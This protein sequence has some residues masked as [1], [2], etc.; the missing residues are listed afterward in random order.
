MALCIELCTFLTHLQSI[1]KA[2]PHT[3]MHCISD[4][5]CYATPH[6]PLHPCLHMC[7]LCLFVYLFTFVTGARCR[8]D[9]SLVSNA[10]I[11]T[12]FGPQ[13]IT[14]QKS[15]HWHAFFDQNCRNQ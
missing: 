11:G 10:P 4:S 15:H 14:S 3:L 9:I 13:N 1:S 8:R 7:C 5:A 2:L 12:G 6:H